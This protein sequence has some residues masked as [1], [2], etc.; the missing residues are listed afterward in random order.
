MYI[1]TENYKGGI[2]NL[3]VVKSDN[4]TTTSLKDKETAIKNH[5]RKLRKLGVK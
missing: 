2:N 1:W 5:K 4:V 3:W